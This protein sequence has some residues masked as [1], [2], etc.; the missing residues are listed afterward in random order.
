MKKSYEGH[1]I[2][3]QRMRERGVR[4]WGEREEIGDPG[5]RT[6]I[7]PD[8]RRLLVDVVGQPWAPRKG[9]VIELG[10]GT[11]P[12]LRWFCKRGFHGLGVD[13]SRTAIAMARAQS[14]GVNARFQQ[15][16]LCADLPGKPRTFDIAL[17]G[18]CLHC[19]V[20]EKDRQAFLLNARRLLRRGGVF[21]ILSMCAPVNRK[22]FSQL[23]QR[24]YLR[25]QTIYVVCDSAGE[26]EGSRRIKGQLCMPTRYLGHWKSILA[27]LRRAG[28]QSQL[29]RYSAPTEKEPI[30]CLA[31]AALA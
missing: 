19:I 3:Y 2:V 29:L 17:D 16:D 5:K 26:Y 6:E 25:N 23:F 15:A 10:C 1:D 7:D 30:G 31:V 21:I 8:D 11:A 13:V 18:H 28:F 24:Q 9:K 27:E 20:R 4:S 14:R 22:T 12:M